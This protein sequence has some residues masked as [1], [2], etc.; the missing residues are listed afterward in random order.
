VWIC[1]GGGERWNDLMKCRKLTGWE[2]RR[3]RGRTK[4]MT[5][6]FQGRF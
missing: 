2:L 3:A 5:S 1:E 6:K 4:L